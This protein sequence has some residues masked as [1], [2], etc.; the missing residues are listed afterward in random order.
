MQAHG[1]QIVS[2]GVLV[3]ALTAMR[4][5]VVFRAAIGGMSVTPAGRPVAAG[6]PANIKQR[7]DEPPH[8]QRLLA[9][10]YLYRNA[11]RWRRARALGAFV[12]AATAPVITLLV[13]AAG[14]AI[15]AISAGW[16]VIGRTGLTWIEQRGTGQ[17]ARTQELYDT[18][19]FL[20]PWNT[21]LVGRPPAPEDI[22]AAARHIKDDTPYRD[23]YSI[24]L[25]TTPWPGDVLLCQRQSMVWGRRDHHAY[26]TALLA[27]GIAWLIAGV[28]IAVF[29]ELTLASYLVKIFLPSSPAFLDSLEV[30]RAH[31]RH[32]AA[33]E[34]VENHI[35]DL[36]QAHKDDPASIPVGQCREIQDAAF[37]LRRDGPRVPGLF[38]KLRLKSAAAATAAGTMSLREQQGSAP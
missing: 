15:A 18:G 14:D 29:R 16:L 38:Y 24:D 5:G 19:L 34:E 30:A 4:E 1:D 21:A 33:R 17:A 28:L 35:Y 37:L 32:A 9:Y 8:L 6:Q 26:G 31:W 27:A 2:G 36:W 7:Q 23:W 20:L 25:G 10:S 12:L 13:P 11:Q 22:A 3:K